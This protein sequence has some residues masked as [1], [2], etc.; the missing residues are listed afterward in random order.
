[1]EL[2]EVKPG[3]IVEYLQNN[4]IFIGC[5]LEK[6]K[7]QLKV[8]NLNQRLVKLSS[9][10]VLPWIGPYIS[11][12]GREE[13]LKTL[14]E[15]EN[16]R[17]ILEDKIDVKELWETVSEEMEEVEVDFAASLIWEKPDID[18]I[19]ALG[20]KL[21]KSRIYFKFEP[22]LFK[23]YSPK[24][25]ELRLKE[26]EANRERKRLIEE[27]HLFFQAILQ[28]EEPPPIKEEVAEKLK[29]VLFE[30]I[31][32]R[33][34]K[35]IETLWKE[36]SSGFAPN[37]FLPLILAK[38]WGIIPKHYNYLLDQ[39]DYSWGDKWSHKYSD[40]IN[41][42]VL[43]VKS[44]NGP[45][46]KLSVISVDNETTKDIDDAF[47]VQK[48]DDLFEVTVALACPVLFWEFGSELDDQVVHRSSSIYLPEGTTHMLPEVLATD[49]FSLHAKVPK[50]SILI[51]LLINTAGEIINGEV[52]FDW[53]EVKENS[54]YLQVENDLTEKGDKSSFYEAYEL[55][56]ILRDKR[57]KKGAVIVEQKEPIIELVQKEDD[58][59]VD[60][61]IKDAEETP[62]AQLIVSELMVLVN[63]F[64]A[65]WAQK[66]DI[67]LIYR[68]QDMNIP[69]HTKG[70]W[71]DPVDIYRVMKEMGP[72]IL[73]T[74]PKPHVSLG[75][76]FYSSISSPIR[77]YI[78]FL[79]IAQIF[80][81]LCTSKPKFSSKELEEKIPYLTSRLQ[82]VSKI[83]KYRTRYWKL[84]YFKRSKEKLSGVV[85][86]EEGENLVFS[87]PKEQ[88]LLKAP[89]KMFNVKD[90]L[91][92]RVMLKLG[93]VDPL[94]NTVKIAFIKEEKDA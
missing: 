45:V 5:V 30:K 3:D 91:G 89:K 62:K 85:V 90:F 20:R 31:K 42:I 54:T 41:K 69:E 64:I 8:I 68:T 71:K 66:R 49:L 32:E 47:F 7:R 4:Q 81:F 13:I 52:L 43:K 86:G 2:K 33:E 61:F 82:L 12:S 46:K 56:T 28:G 93:Y 87:L 59:D 34:N 25:V 73:E 92:K 76:D 60:V 23:V 26:E 37:P 6:E 36:L 83:Q 88:I 77:R 38:K 57:I 17:K 11:T 19:A 35:N 72:S 67:P 21:F 58:E 16:K 84:L 27:G 29:E 50:P 40:L 78:D 39:A 74:N 15:H 1:M 9:S 94:T 65:S 24:E 79:N 44:Y 18:H 10:R 22:P 75:V 51:K 53:I 63:S 14:S 80:Y 70:I 48:K 55:A